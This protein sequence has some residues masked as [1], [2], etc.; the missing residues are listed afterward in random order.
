[1]NYKRKKFIKDMLNI[2][3]NEKISFR[4]IYGLTF[5]FKTSKIEYKN[6]LINGEIKALGIIYTKTE[7]YYFAPFEKIDNLEFI[8]KEYVK[9]Y[10]KK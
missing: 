2:T 3:N 8:V 9:K 10:L 5:V 6:T 4:E 7:D 1:M